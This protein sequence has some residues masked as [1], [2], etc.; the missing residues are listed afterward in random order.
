MIHTVD[1]SVRTNP[2][3]ATPAWRPILM[4]AA[5]VRATLAGTKTQ[6]RRLIKPWEPRV[7]KKPTPVPADVAYL[8]DFTCYRSTC[9]YGAPGDRLWV[10]EAWAVHPD[11]GGRH[12]I[13]RA[14]RGVEHDAD[15]WT[16]S[17]HM[18]RWASRIT[19]H[20]TGVRVERLRSISEADA[21][22][23]GI[24]Q[25]ADGGYGLADTR[26][27]NY[28]DPRLSFLS[29]WESINGEGSVMADPWVWV[30]EFRRIT[31]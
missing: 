25:L 31:P 13:Y 21:L 19:L 15:R 16:P 18:P 5:M 17:I 23:E 3:G 4:N 20:I 30:V 10:R 6:T 24:V 12:S 9:P 8:P 11:Y 1:N 2:V 14:D 28:S 29:L 7:T 22:A 27:N 26:F